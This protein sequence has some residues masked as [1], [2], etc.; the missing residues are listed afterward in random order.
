L[1][2]K[3]AIW[4]NRL[5]WTVLVCGLLLV[6]S[7]VS[8]GRYYVE[9]VDDY[10]H[11]LLQVINQKTGL[12]VAVEAIDAAWSQLSP[13]LKLD[14]LSLPSRIRSEQNALV[15]ERLELQI[16]PLL[17]LLLGTVQ[18]QHLE[19]RGL[20]LA[21]EEF[22][23]GR[24]RLQG[25][26]L[27]D[28]G[29]GAGIDMI[30][31]M[32]LAAERMHLQQS[33]VQLHFYNGE[34]QQ[35][36][37]H[38]LSLNR[39][40]DF[41]RLRLQLAV[42]QSENL[43]E[44]IVEARGDPRDRAGFIADAYGKVDDI[45][46]KRQLPA[47]QNLGLELGEAQLDTELWLQ[48]R[49]GQ[50][51]AEGRVATPMVDLTTLTGEQLAPIENLRMS[52][53][54]ERDAE[55][56][57]QL[58]MPE[59][60]A[61]WQK[62][63]MH[64][65]QLH[66]RKI[67]QQLHLSMPS[68]DLSKLAGRL[69]SV[70]QL[71]E[72]GLSILSTLSPQGSL[73]N[74]HISMSMSEKLADKLR[75]QAELD[76]VA[77]QPWKGAPGLSGISGFI[78]TGLLDGSVLLDSEALVM[79]FPNI[80]ERELA[81]DKARAE[82]AWRIAEG[83]VSVDSGPIYLQGEHGP[84]SGL[85]SLYLPIDS[86]EDARLPRMSLQV[87][88]QDTPA[89]MR[90]KFIPA[91]LSE[92][93]RRWLAQ[94]ITAG[95]INQA[96]FIYR[97]SLKK[98]DAL[99]RSVQ[100]F[101]D[102]EN[103]DLQFQPEWPA[104][105][106]IN[107]LVM[108][109]DDELWVASDQARMF[110]MAVNDADVYLKTVTGE[111]DWL[112]VAAQTRGPAADVLKILQSDAMRKVVGSAFDYWQLQGIVTGQL[113]LKIPLDNRDEKP[114]IDI[115]SQL[116]DGELLIEDFNL[117]FKQMAGEISYHSRHGLNS[118]GVTSQFFGRPLATRL[119]QQGK[120]IVVKL[121]GSIAMDDVQQWTKQSFLNFF[122]GETA[123]QS[124]V[125]IDGEQSELAIQSNLLGVAVDLPAP[126]GKS[127]EENLLFELSLP[128]GQSRAL[129]DIKIDKLLDAQIL[130][131]ERRYSGGL[132]V[133]GE[134]PGEVALSEQRLTV[135]GLVADFSTEAWLPVLDRYLS[136]QKATE[137]DSDIRVALEQLRFDRLN[138][139]GVN[140]QDTLVSAE[141]SADGWWFQAS[142]S[143]LEGEFL[144]PPAS[145][146]PYVLNFQRLR[147]PV[148]SGG[149]DEA[150]ADIEP[151]QL[152]NAQIRVNQLYL[153]DELLGDIGFEMVSQGT[154]LKLEDI[155][156]TLRGVQ[157][158]RVDSP[159][160][161]VWIKRDGA[162]YSFFNG[163]LLFKDFGDVLENWHY[164][165]AVE[166]ENGLFDISL[167]WP[168][169]P[170]QWQ[171]PSSEGEISIDLNKG[172][173]MKT[174]GTTSGALKVVGVV[175]FTNIMRRLKLDFSDITASGVSFDSVR[176]QFSLTDGRLDIADKLL[177]KSP[178]SRFQLRGYSDLRQQNLD[179]ELVATLPVAGNLPWVAALAGGL[180]AAAGVYVASKLFEEKVDQ[181]SSAIYSIRGD[182]NEPEL[183]FERMF[184][185]K[186][187]P[188]SDS[189]QP[190]DT[191][192]PLLTEPA[193]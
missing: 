162:D 157:F 171:L 54:A 156:G 131:D 66:F 1:V 52:L 106:E 20:Q 64:F 105:H 172:R 32:L 95:H 25:Y 135:T 181:F 38:E 152:I 3:T 72:K 165:R 151:S 188:P 155:Q 4:L 73:R 170:D 141:Q 10:Q 136:Y 14:Q 86:K 36:Q 178:S 47:L 92:N 69:L 175:N 23:K 68:L 107:G 74:I 160:I 85:L 190:L 48:L 33:V 183:K 148:A 177:I 83:G 29:S 17:S 99:N 89:A 59:L 191:P 51:F 77:V 76:R 147:L 53:M 44:V 60:S 34:V 6:A 50:W 114:F 21:L 123:F 100:L 167:A 24:W 13:V 41:R 150:F 154:G 164:E 134:G 70:G 110:G 124:T 174:S 120:A 126:Y 176:G 113:D 187:K 90:D 153:G 39:S 35:L 186:K 169:R 101:V 30:I 142:N 56:N 122:A 119:A 42:E 11:E 78:D 144:L 117:Q 19:V 159:L 43:I 185:D 26:P 115:K 182:W 168:G 37:A 91:I 12:P 49:G 5:L 139:Y 103:A 98:A 88:L 81:F 111:T 84:A 45:D 27:E 15:I 129:L 8:L 158:G 79:A 58:W 116:Q 96:G 63:P 16:Q 82:V 31:D 163:G 7:Y 108:V 193:P 18:L 146:Q 180:P 192:A 75:L 133:L 137:T 102:I 121:D 94:S 80:Y 104:L 62:Q 161:F 61:S 9:Y 184:T 173:F 130:F 67:D 149:G 57:L 138:V 93:L 87:G 112:Q 22:E 28:R 65:R 55:G 40:G 145:T 143:E 2:K 46:F 71:G 125:T 132:I 109:D 118:S 127:A 179:M 189:K 166:S 140:Y 97:G 128:V